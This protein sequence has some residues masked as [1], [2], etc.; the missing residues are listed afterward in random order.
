MIQSLR[1]AACV[2]A[3]LVSCNA[4]G[5]Y[6]G[7]GSASAAGGSPASSAAG[8]QEGSTYLLQTN[9]HADPQQNKLSS[10]NYQQ[11]ILIPVGTEVLVTDTGRKSIDFTI[12]E[13]GQ[14]YS[15]AR[16]K[17]LAEPFEQ[18]LTRYF[19]TE[20]KSEE[21]AALSQ[22]DQEGIREGVAKIGMTK[23]GVIFA[24]GYPP[25]H[26]TPSTDASNWTY[27]KNNWVTRVITFDD[28]GKVSNIQG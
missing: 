24:C 23:Q 3:L 9:L 6:A 11:A 16:Y 12:P 18:H 26:R 27:W 21:I 19:G 10:V 28:D 14:T 1:F 17:S 8:L 20:D 7:S 15:Y 22:L 5:G 4:G 13:S 2:A 25:D